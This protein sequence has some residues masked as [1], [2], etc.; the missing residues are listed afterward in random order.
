[1]KQAILIAAYKNFDHLIEIIDFFNDDTFEIYLHIDK[2]TKLP[3]SVLGKLNTVSN[4][5]LLS[6]RYIVNWGGTNQLNCYLL[7]AEEALKNRKNIYFHLISGQDYPVKSITEF[8]KLFENPQKHDYLENFELPRERWNNE[9]GGFDRFL[10]YYFFDI[11]YSHKFKKAILFLV[12]IQKKLSIKRSF[13]KKIKTYYGGSSWW[14]LSKDTL[15]YV[16]DYTKENKYL[17][18][19]MKYTLASDELYFQTVIMNSVYA[20]NV[21]NDNLRYIDW[22]PERIGKYSPSPAI[23]DTSDFDKIISSNKLFA[24][25]FDVPFSDELKH[26][27]LKLQKGE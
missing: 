20:K 6:R 12:K 7:L 3:K 2:K 11:F 26:A 10:Y 9:N 13:P 16:I 5:Q 15:Q 21:I 27:I 19:R 1:M 25:K 18:N 17:L 24:R 14:S 22:N 23:L 8:K 4:L